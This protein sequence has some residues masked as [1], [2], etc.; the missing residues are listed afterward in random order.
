MQMDYS[1]VLPFLEQASVELVDFR[2]KIDENSEESL[3]L[4]G[5]IEV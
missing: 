4:L 1:W 2:N 3:E 5:M